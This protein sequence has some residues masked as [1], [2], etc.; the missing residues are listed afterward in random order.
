MS[1]NVKRY[2]KNLLHMESKTVY[3]SNVQWNW[4]HPK[5]TFLVI[6]LSYFHFHQSMD[7]QIS[8]INKYVPKFDVNRSGCRVFSFLMNKYKHSDWI[9][10]LVPLIS[11]KGNIETVEIGDFKFSPETKWSSQVNLSTNIYLGT[12]KS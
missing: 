3:S 6:T 8:W 1:L 4:N 7:V 2:V 11:R 10:C 9:Y 5:K 12:P